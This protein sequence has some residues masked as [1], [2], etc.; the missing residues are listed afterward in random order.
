M[1]ILNFDEKI[2]ANYIETIR[3]PVEVRKKVDLGYSYN[4][5]EVVLFEIRPQ[6]NDSAKV[7]HYPFVKT[8][9]INAHKHWKIF[10]MS[11]TEKWELYTPNPTV[12]DLAEFVEVVEDDEMG[13]F[14][15]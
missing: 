12:R 4:E 2:I 8:K 7:N 10:W 13:C 9:Y 1:E 5:K 3:P 14:R 6:W 11:A 15:G